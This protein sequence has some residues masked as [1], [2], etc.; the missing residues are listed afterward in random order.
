MT[1]D[2]SLFTQRPSF[3]SAYCLSWLVYVSHSRLI[4]QMITP[5]IR[6]RSLRTRS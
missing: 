5:N 1:D 6:L 2:M 4:K 3:Y